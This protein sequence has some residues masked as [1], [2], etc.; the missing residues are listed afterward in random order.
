MYK[1]EEEDKKFVLDLLGKRLQTAQ[2][3]RRLLGKT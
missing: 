3:I 2:N 1:D